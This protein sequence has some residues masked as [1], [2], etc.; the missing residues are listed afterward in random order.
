[1]E[2]ELNGVW[3]GLVGF[4]R[5]KRSGKKIQ[6]CVIDRCKVMEPKVRYLRS[7]PNLPAAE[8]WVPSVNQDFLNFKY[9]TFFFFF[10]YRRS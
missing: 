5:K 4:I 7:Y 3:A 6:V 10:F 9:G 1:M 2:D 8:I